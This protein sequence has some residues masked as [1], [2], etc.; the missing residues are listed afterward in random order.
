VR[1]VPKV[2]H[3]VDEHVDQGL[4]LWGLAQQCGIALARD[5][6]QNGI[7]VTEGTCTAH[8]HG[9]TRVKL[10]SHGNHYRHHTRTGRSSVTDLWVILMSPSMR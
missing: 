4:L 7:A 8:H 5:V 6:S 3:S 1:T 9:E 2:H 10:N